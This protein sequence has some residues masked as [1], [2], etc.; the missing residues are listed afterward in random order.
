VIA[1]R[2]TP[3]EKIAAVGTAR[4][5]LS[6][7]V[8]AAALLAV[9]PGVARAQGGPGEARAAARARGEQGLALYEQKRWAEAF[10]AFREADALYHAPTLTLFMGHCERSRGHLIEAR[11]LYARLASE[12]VPVAAPEQFRK[13]QAQ[14]RAEIDLLVG[15]VPKIIVVVT[16]ASADGAHVEVDGV[17]TDSG[18]LTAGKALNPGAHTLVARAKGASARRTIS[19]AEGEEERLE[20]ALVA[21]SPAITG[22]ID[23][24]DDPTL[25]RRG[26]IVPG[27][28]GIGVGVVGFSIGAITGAVAAGKIGDIKSRCRSIDGAEHCLLA[29]V[30]ARDSAQT[31]V[32]VS[33]IGLV[34]GG[35]ALLAGTALLI[36]RP[37][38]HAA[39]ARLEI[40][41]GPAAIRLRGSF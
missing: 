41:A 10:T 38:G 39:S 4:A 2:G 11:A 14:A 12:P 35:A 7:L 18:E 32:T 1:S 28:M 25:A 23:R 30:P 37:G 29:D 9:V 19:L 17:A 13:A 15:R 27:V 34:A 20:L 6:V 5:K 21:D 33:T 26:S 22:P 31:L 40:D 24:G 36:L 8:A 3:P 16:G